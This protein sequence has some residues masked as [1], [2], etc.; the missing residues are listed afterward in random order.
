[1]YAEYIH[2]GQLVGR[3]ISFYVVSPTVLL[4]LS[5]TETIL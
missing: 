3:I 4:D 1:M 2:E 5:F